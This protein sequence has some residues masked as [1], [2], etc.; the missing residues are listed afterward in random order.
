MPYFQLYFICFSSYNFVVL[1]VLNP[2]PLKNMIVVTMCNFNFRKKYWMKLFDASNRPAYKNVRQWRGKVAN[3]SLK[4][5]HFNSLR[6]GIH[7]TNRLWSP[8]PTP[9]FCCVCMKNNDKIRYNFA[10]V[11]WHVQKCDLID[12]THWTIPNMSRTYGIF[13][14]FHFMCS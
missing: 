14:R 10:H 13:A 4:N 9:N 6:P 7:I 12:H 11:T 5:S 8:K 3:L 2:L 1:K